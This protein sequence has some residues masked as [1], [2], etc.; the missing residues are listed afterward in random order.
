MIEEQQV[1]L[2][3]I[4]RPESYSVRKPDRSVQSA[5]CRGTLP[6]RADRV[7]I[8]T[9]PDEQA[10]EQ[11]QPHTRLNHFKCYIKCNTFHLIKAGTL[12][13]RVSNGVSN[14]GHSNQESLQLEANKR[15]LLKDGP[16]IVRVSLSYSLGLFLSYLPKTGHRQWRQP[17]RNLSNLVAIPSIH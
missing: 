9:N 2:W 7:W 5:Y 11:F 6:M 16:S 10:S 4:S 12:H 15:A 8:A 1:D 17:K 3:L 14:I 13:W